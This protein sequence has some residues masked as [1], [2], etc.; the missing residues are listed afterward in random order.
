MNSVGKSDTNFGNWMPGKVIYLAG[1]P[2][3]VFLGLSW[4]SLF[5]LIGA[6][7]SLL[8]FLYAIYSHR[9]FSPRGGDLQTRI[10]GLVLDQL[11]WSG[12]GTALDIGCGNGAMVIGLAQRYPRA[13]V[14]GIDYWGG[15]WDYSR[16]ACIRNARVAGVADRTVFQKA[17]AA[18]LPFSDGSFDVAVSNLA[19]HEVGDAR[20]KKAV[21]QEA[22][23][24]VKK[25]G[26]F[27]FQDLFRMESIY[28]QTDDLLALIRGWG[29]QEVHFLDTSRLEFIPRGMKLSFNIGKIG[30]IYGKK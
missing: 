13:R 30:L 24:V 25:D 3:L 4:F 29:I 11:V 2:V 19:F 21:I 8:P 20:D 15:K 14:T 18:K 26:L 6:V 7:I 23:R 17:S 9:Q 5:F 28:G 27:A 16:Q 12:E 1:L 10:R 22:L